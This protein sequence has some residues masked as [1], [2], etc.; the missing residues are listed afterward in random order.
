MMSTISRFF[1]L[2]AFISFALISC[3]Q[4]SEV[5]K[6]IPANA[7][8]VGYFDTK[9]LL[10]KLPYEDVKATQMFRDAM[11]DSS[12]PS[13]G[14]EFIEDPRR[15][16]IDLDKGMTFFTARGTGEN[17]NFVLEGSLRNAADFEKFNQSMEPS[18]KPEDQKGIKM[19][20]MK[21][22]G[23]VA[24]ND[25]NFVFVFSTST[26]QKDFENWDQDTSMIPKI[27][28]GNLDEAKNYAGRLFS[29]PSDSALSNEDHF[30]SLMS[31]KGDMKFWV[32]NEQ[33]FNSIPSMGMLGML[34]LDALIKDSRT[35]YVVKF[36]KG[37]I[38]LDQK[39]YYGKEMTNLIRKYKGDAV[40]AEEF[41]KIPSNDILGAAAFNFKPEGLKEML[42]LMGLDGMANMYGQQIGLTLD[43][44]VG[45]IDGN[46]L[47][48]F[49]DL[50]VTPKSD[51]ANFGSDNVSY[52]FLFKTGIRDKAKFQKLV[53]ALNK[54]MGITSAAA[55]EMNDKVFVASNNKSFASAYLAGKS[56]N[57]ADWI[58]NVTG[59]QAGL[60]IGINKILTSITAPADSL[61]NAMLEKSKTVWGE[62]YSKGGDM[63]NNAFTATTR[64]TFIDKN[65][66]SLKILNTYF[67]QMYQ[68]GRQKKKSGFSLSPDVQ[69]VPP[70]ADSAV[71]TTP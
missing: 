57:K 54:A 46:I 51:S 47:L 35:A 37:E 22:N 58:S 56:E 64:V 63:E 40:K 23:I 32:N 67:D 7:L 25:K 4:K 14:R 70:V 65:T 61:S 41:Q 39:N 21:N 49:S 68:L 42:K 20:P 44:L 8:V 24:W 69:D 43:D 60:Y 71:I 27:P 17:F 9:S 59:Q 15:T 30:N 5:A 29:L 62:V 28:Q 19:M 3:K 12:L 38:V 13:W 18:Q 45:A 34:K 53:D 55:F 6:M 2:A 66:N 50:K 52:N 16:G 10:D 26:G 1:A 31:E 36:D 33:L 48:S 11:T